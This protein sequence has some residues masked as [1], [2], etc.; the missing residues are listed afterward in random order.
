MVGEVDP[1]GLSPTQPLTSLM[2]LRILVKTN[3]DK[4]YYP[5]RPLIVFPC[6][7]IDGNMF[8]GIVLFSMPYTSTFL[9]SVPRFQPE[10]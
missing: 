10:T 1:G 5:Y 4:N 8:F 9:V 7:E 2:I 3:D 6:V